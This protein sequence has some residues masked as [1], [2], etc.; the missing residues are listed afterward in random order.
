MSKFKPTYHITFGLDCSSVGDPSHIPENF[1]L[2]A[3]GDDE[4]VELF[5]AWKERNSE[6]IGRW[7][8]S[9]NGQPILI[10]KQRLA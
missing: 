2:E 3:S 7:P 4:A 1:N 10:K 5:K 9:Q 6:G 8:F